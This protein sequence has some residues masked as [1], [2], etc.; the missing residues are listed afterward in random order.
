LTR[1]DDAPTAMELKVDT[2]AE[3]VGFDAGPL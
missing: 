2:D 3:E 1:V